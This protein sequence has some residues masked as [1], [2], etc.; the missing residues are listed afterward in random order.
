[1]RAGALAA[2]F[3]LLLPAL[4]VAQDAQGELLLV[5][6]DGSDPA[7]AAR[8]ASRILLTNGAG[9][10]EVD[11]LTPW[12]TLLGDDG[13]LG[14]AP[15]QACPEGATSRAAASLAA[16]LEAVS[17]LLTFGRNDEALSALVGIAAALPCAGEPL[18]DAFLA[19]L[20]FLTGATQFQEGRS[21]ESRA[22]F[23][24][25]ALVDFQV[26]FNDLFQPIV[27]DALLAAKE[28]VLLRPRAR[29]VVL[30]ALAVHVDGRLVP[31][32]DGVGVVDVRV[33]PRLIQVTQDGRTRSRRVQLDAVPLRDGV[34]ALALVDQAGLDAGLRVI[35]AGG[36]GSD[37][38]A[39]AVLGALAERGV[40]W[41]VLIATREDRAREERPLTRLD[42]VSAKVGVYTAQT[43]QADQFGRRARIALGVTY[44][45]QG[46]IREDAL[47]YGGLEAALWV[48]IHWLLRAGLSAQWAIT[49]RAPPEG[50]TVCC[51]TFELSP[52]L[53]AEV[54]RGT[55]RPMAEA[56]FLLFWPAGNLEGQPVT[57]RDVTAGFDVGGGLVV[58]PERTRRLGISATGLF[59]ALAGIG[60]HVRIRVAAELRF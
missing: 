38:A 45:G 16:E 23:E 10:F 27:H 47:H 43:S 3:A 6:D 13:W 20:H 37:V 18:D 35:E 52:R 36:S 30:G 25:A 14:P 41:G 11:A 31:M 44:R 40:P 22:A 42:V 4:A 32:K 1:M 53:R 60:P 55:F 33:G 8:K 12:T 39:S 50:K 59:G 19:T 34:A 26:P 7:R 56:G 49:P 29:V 48:P 58:T 28:A 57:I 2:V 5:H 54:S 24:R 15:R 17:G 21:A 9:R 51:S 46:R